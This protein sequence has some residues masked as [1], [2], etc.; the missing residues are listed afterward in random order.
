MRAPEYVTTIVKTAKRFLV[1]LSRLRFHPI[2]KHA[3]DNLVTLPAYL[4]KIL[5][6]RRQVFFHREC[7]LRR[8]APSRIAVGNGQDQLRLCVSGDL[9]HRPK[10]RVWDEGGVR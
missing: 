5:D 9:S 3:F 6:L 10:H 8:S 4:P 7:H 2:S 1:I